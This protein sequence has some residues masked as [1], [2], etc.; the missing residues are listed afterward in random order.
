MTNGCR[1]SGWAV[2][3]LLALM[4]SRILNIWVIKQRAKPVQPRQ[5][6]AN[7]DPTKGP[8]LYGGGDEKTRGNIGGGPSKLTKYHV[9]LGDGRASVLLRGT[10]EDLRAITE[11]SW[12]RAKTNIEGYLEA[13]AKLIVYLAAGLS[14]NM[15]QAGQIIQMILLLTTA[16][17]L[18]LS[19]SNA[20]SFRMNGRVAAPRMPSHGGAVDGDGGDGM[21]ATENDKG[22]DAHP[23][24]AEPQPPY[25]KWNPAPKYPARS[26]RG[27]GDR[28]KRRHQDWEGGARNGD[29]YE[30]KDD[31]K[32]DSWP[33]NGSTTTE[34]ASMDNDFYYEGGRRGGS[35]RRVENP[36]GVGYD[37][38]MDDWAE[39]GQ[40]KHPLR[41]RSSFEDA[42][43]I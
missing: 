7:S 33:I 3:L 21:M 6:P 41:H 1:K 2:G 40:V 14:G 43:G 8:L 34:T 38:H 32:T 4:L 37:S 12:L 29:I 27:R 19:N 17:L 20:K 26:Q 15:T 36:R 31:Y 25:D 16:G 11:D 5:P 13:A 39:R 18:A 10:T 42:D 24:P 22:G 35:V 9:K 23:L 28:E 30:D